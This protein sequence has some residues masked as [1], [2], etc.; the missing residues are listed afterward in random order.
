MI[1]HRATA[2]QPLFCFSPLLF[3]ELTPV[4]PEGQGEEVSAFG[5]FGSPRNGAGRR[6]GDSVGD[7]NSRDGSA[8]GSKDDFG[9]P[10]LLEMLT[11]LEWKTSKVVEAVPLQYTPHAKVDEMKKEDVRVS[12]ENGKFCKRS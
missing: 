3:L 10:D 11:N 5:R 6:G 4:R 12:R 1:G 2:G 7:R 8:G 9:I